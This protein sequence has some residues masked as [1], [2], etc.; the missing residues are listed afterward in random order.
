[1]PKYCRDLRMGIIRWQIRPNS[2]TYTHII[3]LPRRHT[4]IPRET[5]KTNIYYRICSN[6]EIV[7][8]PTKTIIYIYYRDLNLICPLCCRSRT[9]QNKEEEKGKEREKENQKRQVRNMYM[10]KFVITV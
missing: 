1:M 2:L 4:Q 10:N 3:N 8:S 9:R 5:L 6:Y 7:L